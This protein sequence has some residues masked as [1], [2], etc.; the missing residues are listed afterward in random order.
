MDAGWLTTF[1]RGILDHGLEVSVGMLMFLLIRRA[2][3]SAPDDGPQ[4]TW[5]GP[6]ILL[7][8]GFRALFF[9]ELLQ[10]PILSH[11]VVDGA[12]YLD[13]ATRIHSGVEQAGVYWY[14]PLYSHVLAGLMRIVGP[15][16]L[17]ANAVGSAGGGTA[18]RRASRAGSPPASHRPGSPG[19]PPLYL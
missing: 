17:V 10:W 7:F 11:P 2:V 6:L 18:T 14:D 13:W 3:V 5:F 15:G 9:V 4:G 19:I 16:S 8:L 1:H 12:Y